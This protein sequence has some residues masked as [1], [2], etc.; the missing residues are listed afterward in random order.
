MKNKLLVILPTAL[1]ALVAA[2]CA[3]LFLTHPAPF[4][5]D[6]TD[7]GNAALE[8][9]SAERLQQLVDEKASFAVFVSQPSCRASADF[10]KVLQSF[11]A[12]HSMRFYEIA[13]SDLKDLSFA[14]DIRFYPSFLIFKKGKLIDFLEADNDEDASAYTSLD[15]FMTWFTKQVVL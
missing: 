2:V 1:I 5:L 11:V 13:F 6:E 8:P 7:Y 10:E 12:E 9:I 14:K 3:V 4:R 15:G